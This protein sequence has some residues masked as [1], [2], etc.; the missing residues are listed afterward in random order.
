MV[1]LVQV[2]VRMWCWWVAVFTWWCGLKCIKGLH[3]YVSWREMSFYSLTTVSPKRKYTLLSSW[4]LKIEGGQMKGRGCAKP[5]IELVQTGPT[6]LNDGC[7]APPTF[8]L[9]SLDFEYL[10]LPQVYTFF[11]WR[12]YVK[13]KIAQLYTITSTKLSRVRTIWGQ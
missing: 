8:T 7:V 13:F 11:R 2:K 3:G 12:L 6:Q 4:V 5:T 10:A 9:A 1:I